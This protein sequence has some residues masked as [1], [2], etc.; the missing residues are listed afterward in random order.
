MYKRI[1]AWLLCI[2]LLAV[3]ILPA[4]AAETEES[5]Y[6]NYTISNQASFLNLV[7]NCRL[8]SFSRNLRV[9]LKTDID[10]NGTGFEGIPIFS[11]IFEGNGHTIKGISLLQDGSDQGLFRY[12]TETAQVRDLKVIGTVQPGGSG[13]E[14]GGI[15]GKNAGQIV[16]CSFTGF[17]SGN[18]Y[19]GGIAGVNTI[20]GVIE[21]CTFGGKIYGSHFVGGIAGENRGVIRGCVNEAKV[22][23]TAVENR[24][25]LTDITLDSLTGSESVSTVTDIGGIAGS[26]IGVIRECKNRGD[27]GYKHMGYNIGGIA[28][29]QSGALLDSN[30]FG[31]VQGRKEVGGIVGQ[32]EPT[33]LIN[34]AED[35]LQILER[36]LRSMGAVV[37]ETVSNVQNTSDAIVGQVANLQSHVFDAKEAVESL[38]PDKENP[39]LPDADSIQ[40]AQNTISS[41]I[42]GMTNTLQGMSDMAYGS[43]G[44]M[45]TN[46]YALQNQIDSMRATLGNASE[47]LGGSLTDVSDNDTE[48]DFTG[49]VSGCVN[50][51]EVL[52]DRNAGGIAGAI[53]MENDLDYEDD[54]SITGQNSL[55]FESELRSVITTCVNT[56]SITGRKQNIGGIVGL[57]SMG[58]VK[59]CINSG[60]ISAEGADHVGGISGQSLGYIRSSS[61]KCVITAENYTGGIAGSATIVSDCRSLVQ[62]KGGTEKRGSILGYAEQPYQ[63]LE[64]PITGNL[65]LSAFE[66]LG[67]IDGISYAGQAESSDYQAFLE[68]ENLP[69]MFRSV[70]IT[71]RYPNGLERKYSVDLGESFSMLWVPQIPPKSGHAAV[72]AGL[73][74]DDM[75]KVLFDMT[76]EVEYTGTNDTLQSE[77]MEGAYPVLLVQGVFGEN[78]NL[79]AEPAT[80]VI[81]LKDRET[82]LLAWK[83][84]VTGAEQL[85]QVRVHLPE[86]NDGSRVKLLLGGTGLGWR[87]AAASVEGSYLVASLQAGENTVV[88][89]EKQ[90]DRVLPVILGIS[91]LV[92]TAVLLIERKREHRK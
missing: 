32:L 65:Y 20:T 45:S 9:I 6:M 25:E 83:F 49:K 37:S 8:D 39:E 81:T 24:V 47:T 31:T 34:Y 91:A 88:L 21:N 13:C 35:A 52:A 18:E 27:V 55:N 2:C 10:L 62:L 42:S 38:I 85:T 19:V 75:K 90:P 89:V 15:A 80:P 57:Q 53:A 77:R 70:T 87:E 16:G 73:N 64:Q 46:L 26:S 78:A 84:T 17:V 36:Q 54:W 60:W 3:L 72:W 28:G 76:Y 4:A 44:A 7:E 29:T 69:D 43:M 22:N 58:L 14:V 66:D 5:R 59:N 67:A 51:G 86:G 82:M 30:N 63:E 79:S 41:S 74:E 56:A 48:D 40:A 11:G 50:Y 61:A 33:A 12:L 23:D 92:L 1:G 68:L 71:F